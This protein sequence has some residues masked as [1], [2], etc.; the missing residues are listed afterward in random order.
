MPEIWRNPST[1]INEAIK[2]P[3]SYHSDIG[4]FFARWRQQIAFNITIV[5][6][7]AGFHRI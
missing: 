3:N 2:K 6:F 7:D 1:I 4:E 5:A